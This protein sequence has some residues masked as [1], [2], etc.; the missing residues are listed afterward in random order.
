[1]DRQEIQPMNM[2]LSSEGNNSALSEIPNGLITITSER[3]LIA[4]RTNRQTFPHYREIGYQERIGYLVKA[5]GF[6]NYLMHN[7][8]DEKLWQIEAMELDADIMQGEAK[9]LTMVEIVN[10]L[11]DGTKG[12]YGQ[13]YNLNIKAYTAF[14]A[15]FIDAN[16]ETYHKLYDT[17]PV[18]MS[19]ALYNNIVERLEAS[20]RRAAEERKRAEAAKRAEDEATKARIISEIGQE[21]WDEYQRRRYGTST[22]HKA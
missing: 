12:K 4:V 14:I 19:D 16:R 11:R 10:A 18:V 13:Y 8:L 3:D 9:D 1:M 21:A 6:C 17:P 15:G 2:L 7:R 20:K 5:I 22:E